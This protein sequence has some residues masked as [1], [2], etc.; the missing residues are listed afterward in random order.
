MRKDLSKKRVF[1][2]SGHAHSGKTTLSES[3]LFKTKSIAKLGRI[4][5]GSTLSDYSEDEISRR[6]SINNS[7]LSFNHKG[8]FIQFIDTPG[9]SDFIGELISASFAADFAVIVIDASAGVEVGTEK[10]W[11]IIRR[12]D[13]PCLFFVNK[14]DKENTSYEKAIE[15]IKSSLTKKAVSLVCPLGRGNEFK[16]AVSVLD[17][18]KTDSLSGEDKD[19][20]ADFY[21]KLVENIAESDDALLEKYLESGSLELSESVSAL[22]TA[23][24]KGKIFLVL[25]GSG[26]AL[27]G[28]DTLLD[29]IINIMPDA[30]SLP[31]IPAKKITGEDTSIERKVNVP[32]SA[33]VVKTISDPY[34]GQ[35]SIF[36][37]FSGELSANTGFYNST[38]GKKERITQL[39]FLQGKEQKPEETV[40]AGEVA[41]VAKLKDTE[42]SDTLSDDKNRVLFE[43]L[44][45]PEAT[46]SASVKPKT[47]QDEEKI[48]QA[49]YKLSAEDP[50]F[51]VGRDPQTKELIVSGTGEL[52]IKIIIGRIKERFGTEVELGKP[53][54]PYKETIT[55]SVQAQGKYKK[56]TGGHGQYGDVW[57]EVTPLE[58]GKDFEFVDK[59]VGGA[60]PR[61]FIPSVE[62]GIRKCMKDGFLAGYPIS[63]LRVTLF[64]GSYHPVDSSDIAFQIAAAMALKKALGQAKPVLLEPVM[65]VE[66]SV[67]EEFMGQVTGDINSRRGRVQGMDTKGHKEVVKAKIPLSEMFKYASDL[68]SLTGGRGAYSMSFSH[69]DIVPQRIAQTI[70]DKAAKAKE[71]AKK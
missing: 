52:H 47:R 12:R 67:P 11:D 21:S 37:V 15:D 42:T 3:L 51:K 14:L 7:F 18:Q 53:K 26:S 63:D 29:T 70:I 13:M 56:Q 19:K 17:K 4:E 60:I 43:P 68:R 28:I 48:S 5:E 59:I 24:L 25:A 66:I 33:Q 58:R 54:V 69:Y 36:R 64:D 39:Y 16:E 9:Y 61:N 57:I 8:N 20:A 38:K 50:T 2:I 55:K 65:D 40:Y 23:V 71:E 27:A 49:L 46:Y 22:K 41:A 6:S 62:K 30:G 31:N 34:V 10:A 44:S 32:F 1:M 45:F 35:L